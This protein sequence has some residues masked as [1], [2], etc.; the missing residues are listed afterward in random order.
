MHLIPQISHDRLNWHKKVLNLTW[1][2]ILSNLSIP[3]TGAVDTAVVGHL[4]DPAYIGAVALGALIFSA[5]YWLMGFLRMATT[6]FVAQAY[7]ARDDEEIV[8]VLARGFGIAMAVGLAVILVQAPLGSAVFWFFEA[9]REVESHA[10]DYYGIRIWGVVFALSNLVIL[11]LL[12]GLQKMRHALVLQLILNGMNVVLDLIFVL[13][14]GWG[15]QGVAA[16]TLISEAVTVFAGVLM[17]RRLVSYPSGGLKEL[18]VLRRDKLIALAAVNF[19]IMIRTVCIEAVFILFM[20]I[21][22]KSGDVILAANAVLLHLVHFLAF[23]LDGFAHAAEALAGNAY[24]AKNRAMLRRSVRTTLGW[25]CVVALVFCAI[26]GLGGTMIIGLMTGIDEVRSTADEYL[27]W[28]VIAPAAC[29]WPFLFDG[30]YIGTMR[31]VEMRNS[32]FISIAVYAPAAYIG[33]AALGNHG[34]WCAILIFML[35]RGG[36]LAAWYPKVE[37]KAELP[38]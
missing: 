23:G 11:G 13:G 1:P 28:L 18:S 12:F 8:A 3:L 2:V 4:P 37:A 10:L 21:S 32:M 6:G 19:N 36:T 20:Y 24:G 16:A 5:I 38:A 33:Y 29:V 15:V 35:A 26:Y 9:T 25:S 31:T 27:I 14:F 34:L 22:A 17:L 30:V 7:G